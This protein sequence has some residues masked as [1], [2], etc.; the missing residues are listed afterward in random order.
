MR[1]STPAGPPYHPALA[2]AFFFALSITPIAA[3]ADAFSATVVEVSGSGADCP[4]L[5]RTGDHVQWF[6]TEAT[7]S[8]VLVTS[9]G[10]LLPFDGASGRFVLRG[11]ATEAPALDWPERGAAATLTGHA[12]QQPECAEL[13]V[14]FGEIA[15]LE[16]PSVSGDTALEVASA[17][18]QASASGS[19]DKNAESLARY[20]R[21]LELAERTFGTAH[22]VAQRLRARQAYY[23]ADT[24]Q[25]QFE[26]AA[27]DTWIELVRATTGP[28]SWQT[29]DAEIS[30]ILA[31]W[32]VGQTAIAARE[33]EPLVQ[34]LNNTLGPANGQSLAAL[35]T[36]AILYWTLGRYEESLARIDT[37]LATP[38]AH[39]D[40]HA[41]LRQRVRGNRGLLLIYV[42]RYDEAV[43][44]LQASL[45]EVERNTNASAMTVANVAN[46]LGM[47]LHRSGRLAESLRV[48]QYAYA[49]Y[50]RT[51]GAQHPYTLGALNNVAT[52]YNTLGAN[53]TALT[54]QRA[55]YE[56]YL[57]TR[58]PAH[59]ETIAAAG[60]LGTFLVY[61]R[62]TAQAVELLRPVLAVA[63]E[64]LGRDDPM[65]EELRKHLANALVMNG[66]PKAALPLHEVG[67]EL[68][69][70]KGRI[71]LEDRINHQLGLGQ[72]FNELEDPA[73]ARIAVKRAFAL[74][75]ER[76]S[77]APEQEMDSLALAAR[78]EQQAGDRV[79]ERRILERFAEVL[80]RI[81]RTS[82][83]H[84]T[85]VQAFGARHATEYTRLVQLLVQDSDDAS[86]FATAERY[87][88][89]AL[90]DS[91]ARLGAD[92]S[93]L[94]SPQDRASLARLRRRVDDADQ[95]LAGEESVDRQ[96]ALQR[97]RDQAFAEYEGLRE[98]LAASSPQFAAATRP[99]VIDAEE[100]ARVLPPGTCA[101]SFV[102]AQE[103]TLAFVLARGKRIT[104]VSLG[105]RKGL[106]AAVARL[107]AAA[108]QPRGEWRALAADLGA[109]LIA[110]LLARCPGET[111]DV[112]VSPDAELATL[113]FEVLLLG[114]EPVVQRYSV[115]YTQS[116]SVYR[117][118]RQRPAAQGKRQTLLAIGAPT[119]DAL[120]VRVASTTSG[121]P[122]LR[123][124]Q[125]DALPEQWPPL[126]GAR[127]ELQRVARLFADAVVLT[128]DAASEDK[129]RE[130][131]STGDLRRFRYLHFA[132][133]AVLSTSVP[134][135]SAVVLR[136]PGNAQW[137][138]YLNAAE[139][140]TLRLESDLIV[141]SACETGLGKQVAGEGV[142]GLPFALFVAGNR[143]TLLTLWKI[144]DRS[145]S[146]FITSFFER[147]RAGMPAA[148]A[149]ALT[150]R[151]F[152]RSARFAHP[153]YWGAFVLYG[154]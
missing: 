130:L 149:L 93:P 52:I 101:F 92:T 139:W 118:L 18:M 31:L 135:L 54:M 132:A 38:G 81:R 34:R 120:P 28:D 23:V 50:E 21:A 61:S 90:L 114:S 51:L 106:G 5:W 96:V 26:R 83:L 25:G 35:N 153:A 46:N 68:A 73:N 58:G 8:L 148:R 131:E 138:G 97:E 49:L 64:K 143:S 1:R 27:I 98:R 102:L 123:G 86:A 84:A 119:Y 125:V 94:I 115:S 151:E 69:S 76:G 70:A 146:V 37:L 4:R 111:R 32:N 22:P 126:P 9:Y 116:M 19:A 59:P 150:K 65:T 140:S 95:A 89:R 78:I 39:W 77:A 17:Q 134:E 67:L 154:Y 55:V 108:S 136:Q 127:E 15:A 48:R 122:A 14:R 124:S 56:G 147:L 99:N 117:A 60:N 100:A 62:Q 88:A 71:G 128:G 6:T 40:R 3:S 44:S 74:L 80:E 72:V 16:A 112:L 53:D 121:P 33:C 145:T 91:L 142:T 42:A 79:E 137:D 105:E 30:A 107:R 87:K 2:F 36:L 109:K 110:P 63:E 29:I 85:H 104:A 24:G 129:V 141:L 82:P 133:H 43:A 10:E 75:Q 7:S 20:T 113:P 144:P 41:L 57:A 47:A 13:R 12:S 11:S 45:A 66:E 103:E 152:V